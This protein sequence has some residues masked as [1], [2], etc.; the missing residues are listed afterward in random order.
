MMAIIN[1]SKT[2]DAEQIG[3]G[4][5]FHIILSLTGAP[6]NGRPGATSILIDEVVN[7]D[8]TILGVGVPTNGTAMVMSEQAVR[9][10]ME[11][12]GAETTET[13]ELQILVK[14]NGQKPGYYQ[15]NQSITYSDAEG[16]TPEFQNPIVE[17]LCGTSEQPE[18][19]PVPVNLEIAGCSGSLTADLG[20]VYLESL[21]RILQLNVTLKSICP[22]RRVAAAVILT[23]TDATGEEYE[24]G[25]KVLTVPAHN[26][27]AC[28][29]VALQCVKFV[30]PENL[31]EGG[32][33]AGS[34]C[35][36]RSFRVRVLANYIDSGFTC[37]D[38][39]VTVV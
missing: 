22:G 14:F 13:A 25:M 15:V 16:N 27:T 31:N 34:M 37:C 2:I 9:W 4:G 1:S 39:I 12:L 17:S 29:D 5:T 24:R 3:C 35:S 18:P 38:G 28:Q 30:I 23:E 10:Q 6:D 20:D 26:G 19:C 36:P 32:E 11:A 8:F 33:P 21:G 7:Q